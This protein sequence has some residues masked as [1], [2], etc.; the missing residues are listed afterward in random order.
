MSASPSLFL[1]SART[2]LF[3]GALEAE[4]AIGDQPQSLQTVGIQIDWNFTV[5]HRLPMVLSLGYA[6]GFEDGER[7]GGEVLAVAEDHVMDADLLLKALIAMAPVLVLLLVFD[8]LDMFNLISLRA[9][10]RCCVAAGG[11]IAALSFLANWRVDGRLSHRLQLLQPLCRRRSIEE[12]L[13]AAPIVALFA[14]NRL[15][16]KLDAAIAG[17]AVGAGFSVI[18]NGWYLSRSPTP[19]TAPGWCAASARRSCMAARPRCSP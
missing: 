18:E 15:G 3:A 10:L 14:R 7:R 17:F 8:R 4:P 12:S 2:A 6:E 13:K 5:A 11:A 16:F 19:I 9:I 1:S